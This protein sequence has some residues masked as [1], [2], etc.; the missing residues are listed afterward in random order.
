MGKDEEISRTAPVLYIRKFMI[1]EGGTGREKH[2]LE[3][4]PGWSF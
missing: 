1:L 4:R 3:H 2:Q